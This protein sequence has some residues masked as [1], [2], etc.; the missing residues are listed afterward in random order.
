VAENDAA[1]AMKTAPG[2]KRRM[3]VK[4]Q[5]INQFGIDENHKGAGLL[6][7]TIQL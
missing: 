2:E 4:L 1:N 7:R 6:S 3:I 5:L